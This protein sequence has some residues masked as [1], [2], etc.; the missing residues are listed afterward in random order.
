MKLFIIVS[1]LCTAGLFAVAIF[2]AYRQVT[3][4]G[5]HA[6]NSPAIPTN[7]TTL[8]ISTT[9]GNGGGE[10]HALNLY[11]TL[12]EQNIPTCILVANNG[13]LRM[14]LEKRVSAF[15]LMQYF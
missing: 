13:G 3:A 5:Y 10:V 11:K 7:A 14:F 12:L 6:P 2:F 1:L 15:L 9:T 8:I 4:T